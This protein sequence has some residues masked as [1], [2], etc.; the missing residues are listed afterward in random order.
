MIRFPVF[1]HTIYTHAHVRETLY[2]EQKIKQI[3][4]IAQKIMLFIGN[5]L[6]IVQ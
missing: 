6:H 2:I 1:I 4:R 3:L 5:F